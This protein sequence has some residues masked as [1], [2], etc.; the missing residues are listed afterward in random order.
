MLGSTAMFRPAALHRLV[1]ASRIDRQRRLPVVNPQRAGVLVRVLVRKGG[2]CLVAQHHGWR[3]PW[4]SS[5]QQ[6]E[7]AV[8]RCARGGWLC[9]L[10]GG[11]FG[12][13]PIYFVRGGLVQYMVAF[14]V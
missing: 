6:R 12:F 11:A 8:L 14:G 3:L 2:Q 10:P 5:G 9:D 4:P 13:S 7:A 1:A